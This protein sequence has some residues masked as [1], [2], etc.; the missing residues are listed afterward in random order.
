MIEVDPGSSGPAAYNAIG[1]L[2]LKKRELE[3]AREAFQAALEIDRMNAGAYDGLANVLLEEGQHDEAIGH[4]LTAL[5]FRPAQPQTI[6]TLA[7]VLRDREDYPMA[8][9]YLG[10]IHAQLEQPVASVRHLER[11]LELDAEQ[12]EAEQMRYLLE[13]M[14]K[15]AS[16]RV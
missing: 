14:K 13:E 16:E 11:S 9:K 3:A 8:H 10:L 5:R 15:R 2:E 6:T 7:Q 1:R 12:P 4:L